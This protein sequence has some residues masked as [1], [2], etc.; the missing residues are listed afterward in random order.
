MTWLK[1]FKIA[2]ALCNNKTTEQ[3]FVILT[4]EMHLRGTISSYLNHISKALNM[5]Y[6]FNFQTINEYLFYFPIISYLWKGRNL[7][8]I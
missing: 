5:Y 3:K 1:T 2:C 4:L 8:S 7:I 6:N